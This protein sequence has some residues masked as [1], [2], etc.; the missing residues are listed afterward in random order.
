MRVVHLTDLHVE[1]RPH[2]SE[3]LNKRL[4]GS[5]NLYLLGR[6]SKFSEAAQAAAVKTAVEAA[7]DLV[8][9]TG[10]ITAQGLDRE[11]DA[12]AELLDPVLSRTPTVMIAG[13]HDTYVS[14][15]EPAARMRARFGQW[16]GPRSPH[17]HSFGDVAVL[18]LETCRA[19]VLSSGYTPPDQIEAARALI[20]GLSGPELPFLFLAI[21]YPL[22]GR[23]GQ[24]YGPFTRAL[25]NASAVEALLAGTDRVGAVLHGHEHHG[26]RAAVPGRSGPVQI[27]NPGASGYSLI[28]EMRRT[29]HLNIYEVDR[30]GIQN[31]RRL[32]WTGDRFSDEEGGPYATG[33]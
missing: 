9:I 3:I 1:R 11:F 7:P 29:A 12:A 17:L 21:H 2:L 27:L 14:E 16:M 4:I 28:P 26:F 30:R 24:P 8:I 6:A 10:D 31:L 22:R 23:D 25:S 13:N 32:S 19:H 20:D 15:A 18:T 33:R 5:A